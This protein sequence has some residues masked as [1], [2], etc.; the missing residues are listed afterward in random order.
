MDNDFYEIFKRIEVLFGIM[1]VQVIYSS[2]KGSTK[3]VADAIASEFRVN[4]EDVTTVTLQ[5]DSFLFLGSGCYGGKP[6]KHMTRFIEN[7]DFTSRT[8][9]L[10]GT[11]GGGDGKE[12]EVM[13][14]MLKE[15][16]ATVK[17]KYFCQGR[18]WFGNKDKPSDQ[19][20][21]DAK[22]FAKKMIK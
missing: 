6:G 4:A 5:K 15:K 7:N 14:M 13:E 11:S 19:D 9:A 16:N 18:F 8:I 17:G 3:K 12:T 22:K 20:L 21:D 1:D 10:F 2:R